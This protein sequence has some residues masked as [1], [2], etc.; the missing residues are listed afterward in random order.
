MRTASDD[1]FQLIKTLSKQE[2]R[3]FKLY[4]SRHVIGEQNNYL[5]LFDEIDKQAEYDEV[6]IKKKFAKQAFARQLHVIKNY[7][8]TLIMRSLR[9][10]HA[11]DSD[12]KFHDLLRDAQILYDKGLHHQSRK[13]L[14]TAKK[15]ATD[16]EQFLQL[17]EIQKWEHNIIH[18]NNDVG[19]LEKYVNEEVGR[20]FEVLEKY[21]NLLSFKLLNDKFFIHYWKVGI[22]R[23]QL[24]KEKLGKLLEPDLYKDEENAKSFEAKFY[25]YN[26][27]FTYNFCTGN[28]QECYDTM[29]HLVLLIESIDPKIKRYAAKYISTLNNLYVV[30]KEIGANREALETLRK[31]REV[32]VKSETL[33]AEVFM[34]SYIL[35]LDL[36]IS[37]GEFRKATSN[38]PQIEEDFRRFQDMIEKQSRLA[39]FYNFSYIYFGAG[40]FEKALAWNNL[41]LNDSD[42]SMREDIHCFARILNLLI[43]Y[44]LGNDQLLEYIVTSTYRF[45]YKRKRLFKVETVMLNFIKKYPNWVAQKEILAGFKELLK[46][47]QK[48]SQDDYEKRAFDY[49]DFISWLESKIGKQDFAEIK[50]EKT[51]RTSN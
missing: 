23:N 38:L 21:K 11:N 9:N 50:M 19:K 29:N 14:N 36:Y 12:D 34:R 42:L 5:L 25:Y 46:D 40:D 32:P 6:K 7:L 28:L 45:L 10:F 31:L 24:E 8:N 20:E 35:E 37:T 2:K 16:N 30:Q 33:K 48:L 43:H 1:L 51:E 49:F 15:F 17:L 3:Y 44:E 4:A 47:L 39:F 41:L 22:A 27:L 18:Q 26:A 13:V